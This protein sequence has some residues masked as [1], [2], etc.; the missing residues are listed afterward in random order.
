MQE[1]KDKNGKI[2]GFTTQDLQAK[3]LAE[4]LI[5]VCKGKTFYE[6]MLALNKAESMLRFNAV[7]K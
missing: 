7:V 3:A 4:K 1:I 6:A 5:E 2:I